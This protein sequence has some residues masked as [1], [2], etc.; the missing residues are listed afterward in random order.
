V[1]AVDTPIVQWRGPLARFHP[2]EMLAARR[3]RRMRTTRTNG[4][5]FAARVV[6]GRAKPRRPRATRLRRPIGGWPRVG[7]GG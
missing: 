4:C 2:T 6:G 3:A 5:G 7:G 1:R